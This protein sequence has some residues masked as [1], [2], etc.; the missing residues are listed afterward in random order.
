MLII[1]GIG[2]IFLIAYTTFAALQWCANKKAAEAAAKAA[3]AARFRAP[4][5]FVRDGDYSLK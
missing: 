4:Q 5:C 3:N 2:V 1:E